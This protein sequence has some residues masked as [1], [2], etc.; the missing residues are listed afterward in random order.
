MI[1]DQALTTERMKRG[2]KYK[3]FIN[4]AVIVVYG[5]S[6]CLLNVTGLKSQF[7][8]E[9]TKSKIENEYRVKCLNL[10]INLSMAKFNISSR[11]SIVCQK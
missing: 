11:I 10:R 8:I 4:K 7:Q 3:Y 9:E 6:P 2:K 1:V 5:H